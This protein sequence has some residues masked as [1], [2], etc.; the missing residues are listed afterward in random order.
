MQCEQREPASA[1]IKSCTV[2]ECGKK[3]RSPHADYCQMHYMRVRRN[4]ST[5]AHKPSQYLMH[6]HGYVLVYAPQHPL[7]VRHSGSYEY[8]HRVVFYDAHGEGP[9]ECHWCGTGIS[10]ES[11]HVD[12][13][14]GVRDHNRIDNL[15]AS[16]PKCN[17]WR[18][19]EKVVST[20]REHQGTWLTFRGQRRLLSDWAESLGICRTALQSRIKSGW[21]LERAL[22]EPRGETG[23]KRRLGLKPLV[24]PYN[25]PGRILPVAESSAA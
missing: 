17:Q 12:H 2:S 23:P 13:L 24:H 7:T 15:V 25:P 8:E 21:P 3:V 20:I 16:C 14:N 22:T 9:F 18:G 19:K 4:G 10:W 11:M 6:S 1:L 5:D